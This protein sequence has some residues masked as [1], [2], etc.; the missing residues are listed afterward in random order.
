MLHTIKKVEHVEGYKLKLNFSDGSVKIV[1][2]ANMLKRAKNMF[3]PLVDIEYF[4]KVKC[5]GI[6]ISW[7]NGIDLC[8]DMLFR[9]GTNITRSKR[10]GHKIP[11]IIKTRRK[12]SLKIS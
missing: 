5:D 9:M 4:K 3:L 2:L 6:T 11:R 1:D 12:S 10:M 8:P 7:P